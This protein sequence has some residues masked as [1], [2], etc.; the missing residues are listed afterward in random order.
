M[1]NQRICACSTSQ[2]RMEEGHV[3]NIICCSFYFSIACQFAPSITKTVFEKIKSSIL[4]NFVHLHLYCKDC[5]DHIYFFT[6]LFICILMYLYVDFVFSLLCLV[7]HAKCILIGIYVSM[8]L[9]IMSLTWSY[10][11]I[12][13]HRCIFI[14]VVSF[15]GKMDSL[16]KGACYIFHRSANFLQDPHLCFKLVMHVPWRS[17]MWLMDEGGL[18]IGLHL[19]IF[20]IC[21]YLL[22]FVF[23]Y[24]LFIQIHTAQDKSDKIS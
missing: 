1:Y 5:K 4:F 18:T 3:S 9:L 8:L 21:V 20:L 24:F 16:S 23:T 15:F 12:H 14:C 17:A 11:C 19:F 6:C 13:S 2:K 22:V 7:D 10:M